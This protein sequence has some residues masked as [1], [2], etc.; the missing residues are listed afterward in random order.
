MVTITFES[1]WSQQRARA[2]F[3]QF[4]AE[5]ADDFGRQGVRL[6]Q[7]DWPEDT[8]RSKRG[9]THTVE[10]RGTDVALTLLNPIEYARWVHRAGQRTPQAEIAFGEF[11]DRLLQDYADAVADAA[12]RAFEAG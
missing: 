4:W 11:A 7:S 5:V 3:L 8:G 9:W 12:V 6:V 10:V 1:D 2:R